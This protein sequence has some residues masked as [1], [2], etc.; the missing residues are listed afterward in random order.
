MPT[1]TSYV[2]RET[3]PL[4]NGILRGPCSECPKTKS[5]VNAYARKVSC[6]QRWVKRLPKSIFWMDHSDHVKYLCVVRVM[7]VDRCFLSRSVWDRVSQNHLK[8]H[9]WIQELAQTRSSGEIWGLIYT[10]VICMTWIRSPGNYHVSPFYI[11]TDII[12]FL[13]LSHGLMPQLASLNPA[14]MCN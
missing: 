13:D 10:E 3:D 12:S 6:I 11:N 1:K 7:E 9:F 4:F 14:H 8:H 5:Q 2:L